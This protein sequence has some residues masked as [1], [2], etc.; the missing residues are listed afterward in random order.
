M[1]QIISLI[2]LMTIFTSGI[3]AKSTERDLEKI[4]ITID[5]IDSEISTYKK[6]EQFKDS[7]GSRYSYV[8]NGKLR[9]V[10]VDTK[11]EGLNKKVDW[12]FENEKLI[13]SEQKWIDSENKIVN[14]EKI[15]LSENKIISWIKTDGQK[16]DEKS[17]E[18]IDHEL[19]LIE[20]ATS[21]K[22]AIK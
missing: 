2:V 19:K 20:Y 3:L 5:K 18:F 16:V 22:L 13:Y 10:S 7:E 15:F 4:K 21:L 17:Q 6:I 11:H 14:N 12:Y 1:K 9:K 8:E